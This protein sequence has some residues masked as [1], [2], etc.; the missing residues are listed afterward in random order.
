[1]MYHPVLIDGLMAATWKHV[2]TATSAL[3]QVA[4]LRP[5]NPA[6]LAAVESSVAGYGAY[7]GLACATQWLLP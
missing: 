2:L 7:L 5:L 3:V 4:P 6:E 1:M